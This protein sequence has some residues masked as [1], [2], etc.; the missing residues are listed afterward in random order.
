MDGATDDSDV[1]RLKAEQAEQSP[2]VIPVGSERRNGNASS[3]GMKRERDEGSLRVNGSQ[4]N[5]NGVARE[6]QE[7][8]R[9]RLEEVTVSN[10]AKEYPIHDLNGSQ[11]PKLRE[12]ALRV[13]RG[14]EIKQ[15]A[16]D[17]AKQEALDVEEGEVEE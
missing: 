17:V 10:G 12:E 2:F 14:N 16:A 8:K 9:P 13:E 11:D 15:E 4:G 3:I 1:T 5:A 6:A 7:N